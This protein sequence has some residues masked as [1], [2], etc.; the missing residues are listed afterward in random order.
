MTDPAQRARSV[1][2]VV[3]ENGPNRKVEIVS[4]KFIRE[5][6]ILCSRDIVKHAG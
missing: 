2:K 1:K 3:C 5:F 6:R 4:V